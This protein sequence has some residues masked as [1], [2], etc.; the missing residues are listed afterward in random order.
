MAGI[1]PG[2]HLDEF[3]T[4]LRGIDFPAPKDVIVSRLQS[5]PSVGSFVTMTAQQLPARVYDWE[6]DACRE[7]AHLLGHIDAMRPGYG[8]PFDRPGHL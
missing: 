1:N 6:R 7:F 5:S 4:A 2:G 3:A 8:P